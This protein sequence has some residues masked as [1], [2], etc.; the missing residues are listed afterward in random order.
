MKQ[1]KTGIPGAGSRKNICGLFFLHRDNKEAG[2]SESHPKKIEAGI[3]QPGIDTYQKILETGF[4]NII[5][6]NI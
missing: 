1:I 4:I 6:G 5:I 3:R 2:I